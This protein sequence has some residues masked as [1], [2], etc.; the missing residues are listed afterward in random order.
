[1]IA[2]LKAN[3]AYELKDSFCETTAEVHVY[4][5]EKETREILHSADAIC[6]MLPSG[7]LHRLKGLKHGEFSINYADKFADAIQKILNSG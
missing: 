7:R 6:K 4:V 1:M 5:G 2:F 3:T